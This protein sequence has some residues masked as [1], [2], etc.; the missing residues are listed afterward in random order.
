VRKDA[1]AIRQMFET[2]SLGAPENAVGFVLW[3][4]VARYQRE[5]DRSLAP[6]DLTHLQFVT[7]ALTAW[8]GRSG[9]RASQIELA[10]FGGIHPMQ[11]SYMVK[12][13][14]GKGLISR[15]SSTS[16][17]RAKLVALTRS[18]LL[19]LRQA[20]PRVI[21]VQSRLFGEEGRPGGSLLS[22]LLDLDRKLN[23]ANEE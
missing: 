22:T 4:I 3:R 2:V 6:L 17:T 8:F 23:D 14:E 7:L 5:M 19:V 13:L 18:G 9:G 10:R 11:I 1:E 12:T 15:Q 16:D 21:D 20:L